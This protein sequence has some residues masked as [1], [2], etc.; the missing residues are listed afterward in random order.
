M[1][2]V[3]GTEVKGGT[4]GF[5]FGAIGCASG[6]GGPG[7]HAILAT[8]SDLFVRGAS[9]NV[10]EGG[11]SPFGDSSDGYSIRAEDSLVVVSSVSLPSDILATGSSVL[12][13]PDPAEPFLVVAGDDSIGQRRILVFG[14][15]GEPVV[16]ALSLH[17]QLLTLPGLVEGDLWFDPSQILATLPLVSE[18]QDHPASLII[19][20]PYAPGLVGLAA[21]TQ[22]LCPNFP[23]TLDPTV[24]LLTNAGQMVLH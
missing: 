15:E 24:P 9:F 16:V 6:C 5:E 11:V 1:V 7:G 23:G 20:I 3:A 13:T 21:I 10:I 4:G 8:S 14:P 19:P 17:P 22:A 12:L 2:T 18:G